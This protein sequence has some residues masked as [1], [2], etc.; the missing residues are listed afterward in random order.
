M[1]KIFVCYYFAVFKLVFRLCSTLSAALPIM[2]W[3]LAAGRGNT[4]VV[5]ARTLEGPTGLSAGKYLALWQTAR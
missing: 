3:Q 5:R 2:W 1:L 4:N